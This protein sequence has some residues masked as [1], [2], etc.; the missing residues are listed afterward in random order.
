MRPACGQ[1]QGP[2]AAIEQRHPQA[3]FHLLD[4][5]A[6][7]RLANPTVLR[8]AAHALGG[9]YLFEKSLFPELHRHSIP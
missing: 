8:P 5:L 2:L 3:P 4:V 6:S 1:F 7:C 9:R